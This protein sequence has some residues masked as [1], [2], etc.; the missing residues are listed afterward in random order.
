[1]RT[2]SWPWARRLA[3]AAA[4]MAPRR[5]LAQ[6]ARPRPRPPRP[7]PAPS[8]T[9]SP[10]PAPLPSPSPVPPAETLDLQQAV[11]LSVELSPEVRRA[12]ADVA[13][14]EGRLREAQGTFDPLLRFRST[15]GYV[16]TAL[17][18]DSLNRELQRR[19]GLFGVSN[20][21][22]QLRDEIADTIARGGID[23]P[24]CPPGFTSIRLTDRS[25]IDLGLNNPVCIPIGLGTDTPEG[26]VSRALQALF[27]PPGTFDDAAL[28]RQLRAALGLAPD[29]N[30][31]ELEQLGEEQI[32]RS[33]RLTSLIAAQ[34]TLALD[35]VGLIPETEFRKTLA[36]ALQL[37]KPLR[38]G[39]FLALEARLSGQEVNYR[40]KPLD[41]AFGGMGLENEFRAG[42]FGVVNPPLGKRRGAVAARAAERAAAASLEAARLRYEQ[43]VSDRTLAAVRAHVDLLAAQESL[44][45]VEQSVTAQR[46]IFEG[47]QQ[48]VRAG[49]RSRSEL[50]QSQARL[51]DAQTSAFSAQ[52]SVLLA[53]AELS[54]V[55]GLDPAKVGVGPLARGAFTD[56]LA[57]LPDVDAL[58]RSAVAARLDARAAE[59]EEEAALIAMDAARSDLRHR[60]DLSLRAGMASD[61]RSPF[62]RVLRDEFRND[63]NEAPESPVD[64]YSPRGFGRA[65][66]NKYLPDV[67]LRISFDVPF[68]NNAA[69][70]RLQR[71]LA[72][73]RQSQIRAADLARVIRENVTEVGAALRAART[74]VEQRR[75]SVRQHEATWRAAQELRKA[76][77]LSLVDTL[78]TEQG[79]TSARLELVRALRDYAADLARL[80]YE[81]GAL[82]RFENGRPSRF[83]LDG[84]LSPP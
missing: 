11:R 71:T 55:L 58:E 64:Y 45:L 42:L 41:P 51:S 27:R 77:E 10:S 23:V 62:F 73:H 4:R 44:A 12:A 57:E 24:I 53:R 36:F 74:E 35:R 28:A 78:M 52:L 1:M 38:N 82:A 18:P 65:I 33:R 39:T 19:E 56:A 49:E 43:A 20:V 47:M 46:T 2:S 26:L 37:D 50:T 80:R 7:S 40:N 15:F 14:F 60:I 66:T 67:S 34:T 6:T 22:T 59:R 21:F 76:G 29:A 83:E 48:L 25:E 61:Y 3:H 17:T 9:P 30:A 31:A 81:A 63:P 79:L 72:S 8:P 16:E 68:G 54:R 5:A 70:G 32:E 13:L 69:E 75:L 84:L